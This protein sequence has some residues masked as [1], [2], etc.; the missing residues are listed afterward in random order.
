MKIFSVMLGLVLIATPLYAKN[1]VDK[2]KLGVGLST[3]FLSV[4]IIDDKRNPTSP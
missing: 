2:I 3:L 4:L 1:N